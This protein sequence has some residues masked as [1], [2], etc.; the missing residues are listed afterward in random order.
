METPASHVRSGASEAENDEVVFL[1][2]RLPKAPDE[3]PE[4][5]DP[6]SHVVNRRTQRLA[7][8]DAL[9][10][11]GRGRTSLGPDAMW[12]KIDH[13]AKRGASDLFVRLGVMPTCW[14]SSQGAR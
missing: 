8:R 4:S 6:F 10:Y 13:A 14:W 3:T 11:D 5:C 9:R 7:E 1:K 12:G 2:T